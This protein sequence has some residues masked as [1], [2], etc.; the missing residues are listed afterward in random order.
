MQVGSVRPA[1][2][3]CCQ[4]PGPAGLLPWPLHVTLL[5]RPG[6][7]SPSCRLCHSSPGSACSLPALTQVTLRL[8]KLPVRVSPPKLWLSRLSAWFLPCRS[9]FSSPGLARQIRLL[10]SMAN[11][12]STAQSS[13]PPGYGTGCGRDVGLS[14]PAGWCTTQGGMTTACWASL[15]L[16]TSP[17]ISPTA[18]WV[19]QLCHMSWRWNCCMGAT[20]HLALVRWVCCGTTCGAAICSGRNMNHCTHF[21]QG[22]LP[23]LRRGK[24]GGLE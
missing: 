9:R 16:G 6:S 13:R 19:Q 7:E 22:L 15:P 8:S 1:C 21:L 20:C 12:A 10:S 23:L 18:R 24:E 11:T 17:A 5:I 2:R 4:W 14:P 3:S